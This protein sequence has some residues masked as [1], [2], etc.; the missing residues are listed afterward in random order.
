MAISTLVAT[1]GSASAN[2]YATLAEANQ[3]HE[4]RP[5]AGTTWENA[6]TGD[7]N[8]ALLWA[9]KLLDSHFSW[10]GFITYNTQ[11]LAWPRSGLLDK[12]KWSS[13]DDTTIPNEIKWAVSEFAR[14]LLVSDRAGDSDVETQGITSLK[15]GPIALTF[16][17]SVSAK[18]VPDVVA[19]L[20]PKHWGYLVSASNNIELERA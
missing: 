19:N 9:T 14:Q 7:K 6:E 1:A 8:A 16:K 20:I 13:L 4:D 2:V 11:A 3:Y 12:N 17:D 18:P 5:A 10:H 15:A